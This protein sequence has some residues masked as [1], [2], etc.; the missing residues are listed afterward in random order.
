MRAVK[1]LYVSDFQTYSGRNSPGTAGKTDRFHRRWYNRHHQVNPK[2]D[3]SGNHDTRQVMNRIMK[4]GS[5]D[6]WNPTV[7]KCCSGFKL[8]AY[9]SSVIMMK[10]PVFRKNE[11]KQEIWKNNAGISGKYFVLSYIGMFFLL[12]ICLRKYISFRAVLFCPLIRDDCLRRDGE[13]KI[14]HEYLYS[15]IC[16]PTC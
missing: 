11:F 13:L 6:D 9:F 8:F 15:V 14:S 4:W 1:Y 12:N 5:Q 2:W 7:L 10:R 3:K 16:I